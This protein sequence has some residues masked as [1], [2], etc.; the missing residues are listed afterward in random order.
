[1]AST[2]VAPRTPRVAMA[3]VIISDES[4]AEWAAR[5]RET[6]DRQRG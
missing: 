5:A 3:L 1:L 6:P 4:V 2:V